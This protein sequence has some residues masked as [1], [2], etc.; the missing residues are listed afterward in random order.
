MTDK[1]HGTLFI[2]YSHADR[3][4]MLLLRKHLE[5]LL[6]GKGTVWSDE[7][8]PRGNRWETSLRGQLKK[9]DAALLLVT[10]DYLSSQWCRRELKI[11]ADEQ[12]AGRLKK[13]FWI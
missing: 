11:I 7:A 6:F 12:K 1:A 4:Q 9:S 5:G 2:S 10:P 8:I 3:A 13:V